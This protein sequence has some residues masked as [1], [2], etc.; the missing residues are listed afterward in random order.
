[1]P[2]VGLCDLRVRIGR[3]EI[4]MGQYTHRLTAKLTPLATRCQWVSTSATY[5]QADISW[6][7]HARATYQ[8]VKDLSDPRTGEGTKMPQATAN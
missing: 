8:V 4:S 7:A 1:M 2:T 3:E 6:S 5:C